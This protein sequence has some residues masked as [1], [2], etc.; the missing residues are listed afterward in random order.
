MENLELIPAADPTMD[1][2]VT[3]LG[4]D[5]CGNAVRLG[6]RLRKIRKKLREARGLLVLTPRLAA[7][8][9]PRAYVRDLEQRERRIRFELLVLG[10][11]RTGHVRRAPDARG[12]WWI[13]PERVARVF[14]EVVD[15]R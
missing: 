8:M 14:L 3:R 2:L 13:D 7:A 5:L 9:L 15:A 11:L 1:A 4:A 12:A 10:G 6:K